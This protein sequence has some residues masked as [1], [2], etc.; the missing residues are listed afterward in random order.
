M[1][2]IY[3]QAKRWESQVSRP[4]I[5]KFVGALAGKNARKGV[6]FTTSTFSREARDYADSVSSKVIL[7]DG[8]EMV[9]LMIDHDL[10]V[11]D[12][13]TYRIKKLDFDYFTE[14]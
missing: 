11:S 10:G 7:I 2:V 8:E 6:F 1:D 9:N 14:E 12:V 5:Q 3:I 13:E 4:E